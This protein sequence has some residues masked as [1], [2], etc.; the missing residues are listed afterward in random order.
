MLEARWFGTAL[1]GLI[2]CASAGANAKT[3]T[4]RAPSNSL[5]L[6]C[7]ANTNWSFYD[8]PW[9]TRAR[10]LATDPT[11]FGPNGIYKDDFVQN[12][13]FDSFDPA[14]LD[15]AFAAAFARRSR[16]RGSR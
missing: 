2:V 3:L 14:Q 6:E 1:A 8:G 9:Y 15:G 10:Q 7:D 16:A 5:S 13:P 11:N 4:L 12:P